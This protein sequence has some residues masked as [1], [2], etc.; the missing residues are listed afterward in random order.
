MPRPA[1][2][3]A[4]TI[5]ESRP[6]HR[7]PR[8]ADR[9]ACCTTTSHHADPSTRHDHECL[10]LSRTGTRARI[11]GCGK[12]DRRRYNYRRSIAPIVGTIYAIYYTLDDVGLRAVR[13]LAARRPA[14]SRVHCTLPCGTSPISAH[15][16]TDAARCCRASTPPVNPLLP[17]LLGAPLSQPS[18][19]HT[20]HRHGHR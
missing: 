20:Q 8:G 6:R 16:H 1:R 11:P 10:D 18:P 2:R 17:P 5:I 13:V 15:N 12:R 7:P 14:G 19:N 9:A 4:L 3:A